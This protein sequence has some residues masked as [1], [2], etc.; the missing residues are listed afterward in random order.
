MGTI[1]RVGGS[2]SDGSPLSAEALTKDTF[3]GGRELGFDGTKGGLEV[4][5]GQL[6]YDGNFST[7]GNITAKHVRRGTFT[8]GPHVSGFRQSRDFWYKLFPDLNPEQTPNIYE[9]ARTVLGRTW[10]NE[11]LVDSVLL[12][13]TLDYTVASNVDLNDAIANTRPSA[14]A[15]PFRAFLGV[16]INGVFYEPS[17]TPLKAGRASTVRPPKVDDEQYLNEGVY[18]DF[19][20]FS[21]KIRVTVEDAAPGTP[22]AG[23]LA[24]GWRSVSVRVSG[25]QTIRVHGG[26]IIVTPLR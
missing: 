17:A 5:N 7:T 8:Q 4:I 6:D 15:A 22:L 20:T 3:Q 13:I 26:A 9:N 23:F 18:P 10:E 21:M 24:P 1:S 11:T 2:L 19:R 25:R 12:D 16:W 14:V